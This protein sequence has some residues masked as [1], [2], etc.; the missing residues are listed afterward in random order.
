MNPLRRHLLAALVNIALLIGG[1]ALSFPFDLRLPVSRWGGIA[2][3]YVLLLVA[4]VLWYLAFREIRR[5]NRTG[6]GPV[7]TGI[8]ARVRNPHY[9]ALILLN[10]AFFLVWRLWL[11]APAALLAVAIWGHLAW[12]E[13]RA[14][15][16]IF[17]E[18]YREY[19]RRTPGWLPKLW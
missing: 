19:K 8:F 9:L 17:G 13:E 2:A 18:E 5:T 1:F 10:F 12:R 3:G 14:Q 11:L 15:E 4:L 6:G 16:I 7:T